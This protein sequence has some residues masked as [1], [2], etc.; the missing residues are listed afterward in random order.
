MRNLNP[1][2]LLHSFHP[3]SDKSRSHES[4]VKFPKQHPYS[5]CCVI[6]NKAI[7]RTSGKYKMMLWKKNKSKRNVKFQNKHPYSPC[8][9]L[10]SYWSIS[11]T[12]GKCKMLLGNSRARWRDITRWDSRGDKPN[13]ID[14]QLSALTLAHP[15]TKQH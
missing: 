1:K 6:N 12:S 9:V 2:R 7:T 14:H 11:R 10:F 8:C 15:K 5:P 13:R 3:P 4:K